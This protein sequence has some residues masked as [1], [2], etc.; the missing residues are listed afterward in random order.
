MILYYS[1]GY[2]QTYSTNQKILKKNINLTVT[3]NSGIYLKGNNGS[4]KT[5]FLKN[6]LIN[7]KHTDG[8]LISL[9]QANIYM[10]EL[11]DV[12]FSE[13]TT[14]VYDIL[15]EWEFSFCLNR[16][17]LLAYLS[18]FNLKTTLHQTFESLSKGQ[19]QKL[20]LLRV[21]CSEKVIWLLDEFTSGL[22]KDTKSKITH[23]LKFHIKHG[24]AYVFTDHNY[25]NVKNVTYTQLIL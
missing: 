23:L 22:D 17:L 4:G 13:Q 9:P 1:I 5:T 14:T 24:G 8:F 15:Q 7:Y 20:I 2:L 19:R 10:G 3:S 12:F 21:I 16:R 25:N 11:N 18:F 6:I